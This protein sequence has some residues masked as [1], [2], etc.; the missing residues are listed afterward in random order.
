MCNSEKLNDIVS[1]NRVV[2]FIKGRASFPMCWYS[3]KIVQLMKKANMDFVSV[4]LCEEPVLQMFLR[5]K[6]A[7]SFAPYLYVDK[8]FVGGYEELEG[9]LK[10]GNIGR[11]LA[12]G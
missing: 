5:E 6:H 2:L 1:A 9:M 4:N 11:V 3:G 12:Y 7:P 10:S 8:K